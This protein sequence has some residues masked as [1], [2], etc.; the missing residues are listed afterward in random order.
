MI[1]VITF[2]SYICFCK[3]NKIIPNSTFM[4]GFSQYKTVKSSITKL[5]KSYLVINGFAFILCPKYIL[6]KNTETKA[7][8]CP[9]DYK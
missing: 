4:V 7:E 2:R 5:L 3:T 8:N 9:E 6:I 1:D